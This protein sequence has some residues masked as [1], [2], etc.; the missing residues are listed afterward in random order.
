MQVFYFSL[1]VS[2]NFEDI[3]MKHD[4]IIIETKLTLNNIIVHSIL[5]YNF[6]RLMMSNQEPQVFHMYVKFYH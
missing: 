1:L 5:S 4:K 6:R 2:A 3:T